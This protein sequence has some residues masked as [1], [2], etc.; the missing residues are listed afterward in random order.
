MPIFLLENFLKWLKKEAYY[1]NTIFIVI[2]DHNTRTYGKN[3]VPIN[4]FHI[5]ALIIGPNVPKG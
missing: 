5:P 3:L 2:A 1:K 4:K